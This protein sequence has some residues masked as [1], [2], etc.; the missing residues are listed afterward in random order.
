[1][2]V[3]IRQMP[4][5]L[6]F[7]GTLAPADPTLEQARE[8]DTGAFEALVRRHERMVFSLALH[9]LHDRAVAEEVAQEVFLQLFRH[10]GQIDSDAHLTFW[11]RRVTGH[12]AIDVVRR[13]GGRRHVSLDEAPALSL[14]RRDRDPWLE[15]GIRRL[16]DQLP[17]RVRLVLALRY[18]EDLEPT[19]IAALLG[20][21]LN[22]VKSRLKRAL[23]ILRARATRLGGPDQ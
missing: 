19:E 6:A 16:V 7:P 13:E 10:L 20:V 18:Q 9:V 2:P 5:A 4:A 3:L 12:R 8:G 11:L 22:T 14:V 21:P 1:M 23:A 15:R 17:P